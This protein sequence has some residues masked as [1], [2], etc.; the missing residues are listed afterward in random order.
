MAGYTPPFTAKLNLGLGSKAAQEQTAEDRLLIP[1]NER[2]FEFQYEGPKVHFGN[3]R[4]HDTPSTQMAYVQ[5][6]HF[7]I[8]GLR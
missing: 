5:V 4:V 7:P 8:M 3:L 2:S 1:H 6:L